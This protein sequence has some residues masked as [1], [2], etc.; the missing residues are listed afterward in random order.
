M[1]LL[2]ETRLSIMYTGHSNACSSSLGL[3]SLVHADGTL[4]RR[5]TW[6]T[7]LISGRNATPPWLRE[8]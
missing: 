4:Q 2:N 6:L 7:D 1:R 8:W 3:G 5:G